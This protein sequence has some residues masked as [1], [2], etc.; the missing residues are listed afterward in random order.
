MSNIQ[1]ALKLLDLPLEDSFSK[2]ETHGKNMNKHKKQ[3]VF[4][5]FWI[6][7]LREIFFSGADEKKGM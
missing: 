2:G 1:E 3:L 7:F 4:V 6:L 5:G